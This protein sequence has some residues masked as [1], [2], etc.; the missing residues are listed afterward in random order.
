[1]MAKTGKSV[2]H[3]LL[4]GC[5]AVAMMSSTAAWA[6]DQNEAG[7][8]SADI[9]ITAQQRA[10][11]LQNVPIQVRAFT[12]Q[13][14]SDAGIRSTGDIIAQIPNMSFDR[15][16]NYS[17]SFVTMRGLTQITNADPPIA[18]VID[19]VPQTSQE[20]LGVA[21]FDLERVEVLKGP[22]GA[23]YGRNAVGGAINVVTKA[24]SNDFGGFGNLSYGNGDTL[25]TAAGL[26]GAIVDDVLRFRVS[27]T[28]KQSD[29]LVRNSFRGDHSDFIDHDYALRG[30]LLFTPSE[31][32]SIDLR[33]QYR[34]FR[35]GTNGYAVVPSGNPND[36]RDPQFNFPA[37]A[38]G[39]SSDLTAKI[40]YDFGFATL[41]GISAFSRFKQAYR[42]D[43]DFS[44]PVDTPSGFNGL[45]F[46]LG[47]GQDLAQ[48][49][50][51]QE[52]RLVSADNGPLRWLAG[53][54]YLNT[55]RALRTRGF[56][57][58]NS[59]PAQIDTPG[60]VIIDN[61]EVARNN[62]YAGFAQIDYDILDTLTLTGGLRY[63]SDDREQ[64]NVASGAERTLSFD[65]WQPK[66]TLTW[67]PRNGRLVYA[68]YSTGFRSGGFN[69]PNVTVPSFK[70]ETLENFEL[71][72]KT[73]WLD[74]RLTINGSAFMMNVDNYQFF[75][76]DALTASQIIDNIGK[77]RI[78]GIE[79]E[80]I[81]QPVKG[82]EA[83]LAIG[84][85]DTNIRKTLFPD[86][87]GNRTP[88]TTPFTLNAS[89]QYRTAISGDIEG[90]GRIEY[91]HSGKKYWG[92][93][94][95]AV[96][97][98]FGMLNLRLGIERG[99][100]GLYGFARNLLNKSYYTEYV[101]PKYSGL[102]VAIGYPGTPRTY[103]VEAKITF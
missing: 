20:Q 44:N 32:L 69:A 81:A 9:I 94:N 75:Y 82:L 57:D 58:I 35:G 59:N 103:G 33:G 15:G 14:L 24:P 13:A 6:Q 84:Y 22:Q 23:L 41:T 90:F 54:Y 40:D 48:K 67:K 78:K 71:G 51:S 64:T 2:A 25:E 89:L 60:L 99:G 29:G 21:L 19:G 76:V 68:T 88:R 49:T 37:F 27:G 102:N 5:A 72:F 10:E 42:A 101:Q 91:Q 50:F 56:I 96:Q 95:A 30:R 83:G 86:D 65:H 63:D 77:V 46:Q 31:P 17:S 18:F 70:A 93:D 98:P 39:H 11:P 47:Q 7:A 85:I 8:D 61:N 62:A 1:M 55:R 43:L 3:R 80:A 28:Y 100:F 34:D 16:N 66:V 92:A 12:D 53:G 26:S 38:K 4:T 45:G 52:I 36:F 74:R 73:Q 87:I 79:L 97:D